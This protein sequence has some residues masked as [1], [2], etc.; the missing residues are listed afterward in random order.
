M[1]QECGDAGKRGLAL[2]LN[3]NGELYFYFR[4]AAEVGYAVERGHKA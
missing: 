1:V 2:I 3:L 4:D